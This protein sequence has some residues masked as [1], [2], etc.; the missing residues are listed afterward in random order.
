[1]VRVTFAKRKII[2]RALSM[3]YNGSEVITMS[4]RATKEEKEAVVQRFKEGE[5]VAELVK[6]TRFS[7]SSIY[8]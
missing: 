1:M 7:R 4:K 5:T 8:S 6:T 3:C 2:S